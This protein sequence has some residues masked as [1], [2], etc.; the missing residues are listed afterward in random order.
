MMR[1]AIIRGLM[2]GAGGLHLAVVGVLLMLHQRWI[3][4]DTISL[5]QA[6][7]LLLAM[8]AGVMAMQRNSS[9]DV[10]DLLLMG[11]VGGRRCRSAARRASDGN[12]FRQPAVDFHC[13]YHMI[14]SGC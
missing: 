12:E 5:G 1:I 2:F 7:L 9:S 11:F 6:V 14:C 10:A 8:G 13:R 3:V 4:L